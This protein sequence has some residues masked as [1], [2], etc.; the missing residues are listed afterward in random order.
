MIAL[1]STPLTKYTTIFILLFT[2]YFIP[3]DTHAAI[4]WPKLILMG[5]IILALL[6]Y[7][8][9]ISKALIIG[10]LY[11]VY[12]YLSASF[13][14]ESWRW[15]T[16]LLSTA[17]VYTYVGFYNLV[18][19]ERVFTIDHFI[20]ICKWIMMAYFV[21]CIIQQIF[22]IA[23]INYFPPINL[24]KI[25][26]RGIGCNSLAREPSTFA[27]FMLVFYYAYVKCCEYKRGEGPFTLK[28]LFSGEHKWVTIRFLWMMLTMGSGT[29]F[30]CLILLSGYFVRRHNWY[31]VIPIMVISYSLIQASGIESLDRAT[32][33]IEATSTL[34]VKTVR[35]TDGSASAR[36]TP[37]LNSLNADFT[38]FGTWFGYGID[39]GIKH[40]THR[41]MFDDYGFIFYL[42]SLFF[43]FICAYNFWS[44]ATIFMFAGVG[45][46]C[47]SNIQYIWALAMIM[48]CIKYFYEN[49]DNP[50]I[51]EKENT[52]NSI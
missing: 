19:I 12:Q 33:T 14:P 41:T 26:D 23:G 34:D 40:K 32:S 35:E 5:S 30:V 52:E 29:A 24:C 25:L 10:T 20:K 4:G 42:I 48:T 44:L 6:F 43:S 21:I 13:H 45:G 11:L 16:L 28:E 38:K 17:M 51:Y 39:A 27:R 46:G 37:F 36:I 7:T 22:I 49:K 15:S 47:N 31:Y 3:F 1:G 2:T 9:K 50:D 8:F 18:T